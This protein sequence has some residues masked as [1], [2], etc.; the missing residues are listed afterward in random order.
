MNAG[1]TPVTRR[2]PP[3]KLGDPRRPES[4]AYS[5]S[6]RRSSIWMTWRPR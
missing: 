6:R 2:V 4:F 1:G 3:L 5:A